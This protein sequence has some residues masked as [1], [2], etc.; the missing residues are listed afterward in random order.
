MVTQVT[1]LEVTEHGVSGSRK[2]SRAKKKLIAIEK[3]EGPRH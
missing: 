3:R 2:G 1:G